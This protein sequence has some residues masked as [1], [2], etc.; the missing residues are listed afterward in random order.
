MEIEEL[1]AARPSK[2][3]SGIIGRRRI[4][5]MVYSG[6]YINAARSADVIPT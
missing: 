4:F 5:Y 3:R 2:L 6:I 1:F